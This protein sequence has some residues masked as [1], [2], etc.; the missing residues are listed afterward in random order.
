[1][2]I[3]DKALAKAADELLETALMG[4]EWG[5]SLAKFAQAAG[6]EGAT[7]VRHDPLDKLRSKRLSEFVLATASLADPVNEYLAGQ[8]PPDPRLSR[9]SPGDGVGFL[10]DYDQL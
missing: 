1:M 4:G 10:S 3:D 7:L 8:A 5:A 2:S 9:V 6:A